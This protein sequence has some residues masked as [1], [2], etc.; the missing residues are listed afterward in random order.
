[1]PPL[2]I[3]ED[4]S[5]NESDGNDSIDAI[6]TACRTYSEGRRHPRHRYLACVKN[7]QLTF[8]RSCF[9]RWRPPALEVE[10]DVV[11]RRLSVANGVHHTEDYSMVDITNFAVYRPFE[12]STRPGELT[13]LTALKT[14]FGMDEL[15]F[16]GCLRINNEDFYLRKIKFGIVAIDGYCE[17]DTPSVRDTIYIQ[18]T[19]ASKHKIYYRLSQPC[20]EYRRYHEPTIWVADLVKYS[21]EFMLQSTQDI[22]LHSFRTRFVQWVRD[23]YG[24][25]K[26]FEQWL[27]LTRGTD[28]RSAI[29][30]HIHFLWKEA[31]SID[32]TLGHH[33][34]WS[35][36]DTHRLDAVPA[37]LAHDPFTTVTVFV[38]RVFRN[39]YFAP[40]LRMR[41]RSPEIE[42]L[43]RRRRDVL[44]LTILNSITSAIPKI[45][46]DRSSSGVREGDVIALKPDAV[47]SWKAAQ[48][49]WY[50]YVQAVRT[51]Q[52]G[53]VKLD[54]LWL[55]APADTAIGKSDYPYK[56]ELFL[57]D[58]CSC[59]DDAYDS[60][61]VTGRIKV[62]WGR[63]DPVKAEQEGAFVV[64]QTYM[65]HT[66]EFVTVHRTHFS[67]RCSMKQP[68]D[69][70]QAHKDYNCGDFVLHR[71]AKYTARSDVEDPF[72][73]P[74]QIL[75]FLPAQEKV[76]V[77][78]FP[79]AAQSR[80][81]GNRNEVCWSEE[82]FLLKPE[83]LVRPCKV[84]GFASEA[85]VS[86]LFRRGGVGDLYFYIYNG[87]NP[88]IWQDIDG[89]SSNALPTY[90]RGMGICCGG[91][92]L[93]RGLEDG[94]AIHFH[95][96]IDYDSRAI[97]TYR[98]NAENP[99]KVNL[100]LGPME[101]YLV[102]SLMGTETEFKKASIGEVDVIAAGSPCQA[103]STLQSDKFSNQS[104]KR[105]S[106][107]ANVMAYVDH[108]MPL[109][110]LLENVLG[111]STVAKG[112]GPDQNILS[113]VLSCLVGMGYQTQQFIMDVPAFNGFQSRRR[114]FVLAVAPGLEPLP[115]PPQS[116]HRS[117]TKKR[118]RSS[119]GRLSNG[120]RLGEIQD[121]LAPF[122]MTSFT[123]ATSDLPDI[124]DGHV[125]NCIRFPEHRVG[126]RL[127]AMDRDL[128]AMIPQRPRG[129][130]LAS[131]YQMGKVAK[132]QVDRWI[133]GCAKRQDPKSRS[134]SRI[135]G[136][137]LINTVTTV[138]Q[139]LDIVTGRCLHPEQNRL[140]TV[141]EARRAQGYPDDEVILGSP[142]QQWKIIG[143]SVHRNV[144][145]ALGNS[146][147]ESWNN[148]QDAAER[149]WERERLLDAESEIAFEIAFQE[150]L[151]SSDATK[152]PEVL[153]KNE[154]SAQAHSGLARP[155]AAETAPTRRPSP[156]A[157]HAAARI[158]DDTSPAMIETTEAENL[159]TTIT[160]VRK[161]LRKR[162]RDSSQD[163]AV[164]V[165]HTL[166][167]TRK[168]YSHGK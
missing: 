29:S 125:Y 112:L 3:S 93:D 79:L 41:H 89:S 60:S 44:G 110:F 152:E 43:A 149:I 31:F 54:L 7:R 88:N 140:L 80:E 12:A 103:F 134:F 73:Y 128:I 42:R 27:S 123:A 124:D 148:S 32:R 137:E 6:G 65:S 166:T 16:D 167:T 68:T 158:D 135:Y 102:D 24:N 38:H 90:L 33:S 21:L 162:K 98:V 30:V 59:Q 95:H 22:G 50:A 153:I 1:M 132:P 5:S 71:R 126:R 147:R 144:A 100:F 9:D 115:R 163:G 18:S 75:D 168:K 157:E 136:D 116:S 4:V 127:G 13:S 61:A 141:M 40:I 138:L 161:V 99:N 165:E 111:I 28:F 92:S 96:A 11:L 121:E 146:L 58:N 94:N 62:L 57:S 133:D 160:T 63:V 67:C 122:P 53:R 17:Y 159:T 8:P 74:S 84:V 104:I 107:V 51:L 130:G 129:S 108:Y 64:R 114:C 76:L 85:A 145:F 25:Q 55:Y 150:R 52:N 155:R 69:F 37:Y 77:R 109:Y 47:T 154:H 10:E 119:L 151:W 49:K 56:N 113:Q 14:E 97:H 142:D 81:N 70:E 39:M 20:Q 15:C 101:R 72:L 26:Q 87:K 83:M 118:N 2:E 34:L 19:L 46:S 143:N 78:L 117:E 91:G 45:R 66:H 131:A 164:T 23:T 48:A 35:E 139:P 105:A 86:K 120:A 106:L 82:T 36:T 156:L